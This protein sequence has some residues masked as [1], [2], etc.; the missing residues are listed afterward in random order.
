MWYGILNLVNFIGVLTNAFIIAFTS[1]W[2]SQFNTTG[3]LWVVIGFEHI[4]FFLKFVL[5]YLI[6]DVP[7]EVRL[8]IRR[9][10]YFIQKK[11]EDDSPKKKDVDFSELFPSNMSVRE[12]ITEED[13]DDIEVK[14]TVTNR[15]PPV[16]TPVSRDLQSQ[17]N[18]TRLA[19]PDGLRNQRKL[20]D[21]V[22]H[23][24]CNS[25]YTFHS[26]L[27]SHRRLEGDFVF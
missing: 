7:Q 22:F 23:V 21:T 9:E 4:V 10:R 13:E 27:Q 6:P 15:R 26:V 3:K 17:I 8:A 19:T 14:T 16:G 12:M 2:G 1:S 5:A 25:S 11:F 18:R 24:S 20:E